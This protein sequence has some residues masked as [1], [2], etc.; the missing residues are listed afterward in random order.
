MLED[1]RRFKQLE[2]ES[3]V[4]QEAERLALMKKLSVTCRSHVSIS[5]QYIKETTAMETD[6]YHIMMISHL[7][8]CYH[9][10]M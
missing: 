6:C 2:T 4:E 3:K 7:S 9:N 1:W 8:L 5:I 10:R